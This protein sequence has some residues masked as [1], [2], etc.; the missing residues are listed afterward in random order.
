L[1][2]VSSGTIAFAK[3]LADGVTVSIPDVIVADYDPAAKTAYVEDANRSGG[4]R[5]HFSGSQAVERGATVSITGTLNTNSDGERE[6]LVGDRGIIVISAPISTLQPLGMINV[7]LGGSSFNELTPC[8]NYPTPASGLYNKGLLVKIW[9]RVTAVNQ[10]GG[11]FYVDDGSAI[12][13]GSGPIGVKVVWNAEGGAAAVPSVGDYLSDLVGISSSTAVGPG[14]YARLL[15]LRYLARLAVAGSAVSKSVTLNWTTAD[16]TSYHVVRALGNNGPYTLVADTTTGSFKDT[17]L[18]NGTTYYYRVSALESGIEGSASEILALTPTSGASPVTSINLAGTLGNNEWYVSAVTATISATDPDNDYLN[19]FYKLDGHE[20]WT[21]YESELKVTSDGSHS[22][23]AYSVDSNGNSEDPANPVV[24][25]FKIDATAPSVDGQPATQPNANGLYKANVVIHWSAV[26]AISG[27]AAPSVSAPGTPITFDT[28][29]SGEGVVVDTATATDLAGNV[30]SKTVSVKIDKTPPTISAPPDIHVEATGKDG[31]A[32]SLGT[33]VVFDAL[34]PNP[35]V[36]N[37]APAL[38][39]LGT[40]VVTWTTIDAAGNATT[41]QQNVT[42]VGTPPVTVINLLGTSGQSGWFVSPVSV[43]M[44]ATD[45]DNDVANT[46][47]KLDDP[48]AAWTTYSSAFDVSTDG[49]HTVAAYSDDLASNVEDPPVEAAFNIDATAPVITGQ[50][51][52]QPNAKGWYKSDV[53]INWSFVDATSGLASPKAADPGV[54]ATSTSTVSEE[55]AAV[56]GSVNATDVA[57]NTATKTISLN[58]DKTAPVI[59]ALYPVLYAGAYNTAVCPLVG[60][61]VDNLDAKPVV[62]QSPAVGTPLPLG[63]TMVTVTATD[64]AG[65]T[66]T[67]SAGV[68][69]IDTTW[70]TISSDFNGTPITAGSTVWFNLVVKPSVRPCTIALRNSV[71]TFGVNGVPYSIAVPDSMITFSTSSSAAASTTYDPVK[72]MWNTV[73]PAGY[74]DNIFLA[75]ALLSVTKD[76]PGGIK[77]VVW[78]GGFQSDRTDAKLQWKWGAA[79]YTQFSTDYSKVGAKPIEGSKLNPYD[80]SDHAGTPENYKTYVTGGARGG[81]GSNYTGGYSGTDGISGVCPLQ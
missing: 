5:V 48:T 72:K 4:I 56:V 18:T 69:V 44:L 52:T 15:R 20:S 14:Q 62:T 38:F 13:N 19:S 2:T 46:Y 58:I 33:P 34:D 65:N 24:S 61:A 16:H 67:A 63:L 73:V 47:Y 1:Q 80:N 74:S 42:V 3:S 32:V 12:P 21:Q 64:A 81:G 68:T 11:Y 76:L 10:A 29:L 7:C 25:S 77:P 59:T 43:S 9:G 51:A 6:L 55:G 57:G 8:I 60:T 39:G 54:T 45:P 31:T 28:V 50:P 37:D 70:S 66:S 40:T 53:Q 49:E 36:T 23:S 75:G 17:G 35:A 78:S 22:I 30:G 26:D 71:I 41:A 79:V 27:L